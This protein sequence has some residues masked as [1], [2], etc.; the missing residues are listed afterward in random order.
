MPISTNCVTVKLVSFL[1][2][3]MYE[4]YL[5]EICYLFIYLFIYLFSYD[6]LNV[7]VAQTIYYQLI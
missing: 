1:D 5:A 3:N 6:L 4:Y 2:N 7:S